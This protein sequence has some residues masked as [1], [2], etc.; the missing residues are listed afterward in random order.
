MAIC[1]S[2][3]RI[4]TTTSQAE[5]WDD[6]FDSDW[7]E[8]EDISERQRSDKPPKEKKASSKAPIKAMKL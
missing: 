3:P 7:E 5:G 2:S 6:H 1:V 8:G 4:K